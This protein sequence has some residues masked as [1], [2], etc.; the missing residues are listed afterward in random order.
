[1]DVLKAAGNADY[2]VSAGT[3]VVIDISIITVNTEIRIQVWRLSVVQKTVVVDNFTQVMPTHID[4]NQ[5]IT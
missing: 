5:V 2:T 4:E 1:M 3:S